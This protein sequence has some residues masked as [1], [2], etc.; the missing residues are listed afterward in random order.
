MYWLL[1]TLITPIL[2]TVTNYI[3][4]YLIE[5]YCKEQEVGAL[6]IFSALVGILVAPFIFI[7]NTNVVH[8]SLLNAVL[9]SVSGIVWAFA[10]LPYLYALKE[11]DVS[12]ATPIFQTVPIFALILGLI[13]LGEKISL[14]QYIG[15]GI[16]ISGGIFLS[17]NLSSERLQFKKKVF[18]LMILSSFFCALNAFIFKF[19]AIQESFW[20]TAFWESVGL[21][22][23]SGLFILIN[24]YRK[25]FFEIFK[26]NAIFIFS[27][28]V[29]NEI[30]G[31]VAKLIANF[32]TLL[33]PLALVYTVQD[34]SY[35]VFI[36]IFGIILSF[37]FPKYIKEDLTK[38]N[39]FQRGLSI[40]VIIFGI[41]LLK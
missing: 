30:L 36:L 13:F 21:G 39:L 8:V 31:I 22:V 14:I 32:A 28:N 7:F 12:I 33:A 23:T 41:Y 20:T 25:Q 9:I 38:R 26:E 27:I 19:I 29:I 37:L 2:F 15:M 35:P 11:D 6:M 18:W 40:I 1:I 17:I 4:K 3:D 16:V 34:G 5:K 10:V 24:S